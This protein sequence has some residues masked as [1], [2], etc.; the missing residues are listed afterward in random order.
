MRPEVPPLQQI[1]EN[2]AKS[3]SGN[4]CGGVPDFWPGDSPRRYPPSRI[5]Q[6]SYRKFR[7]SVRK[8]RSYVRK[9]PAIRSP[10]GQ[11][12]RRGINTPSPTSGQPAFGTLSP[13]LQ[14][15]A[16][17]D[18]ISQSLHSN[19]L[20]LGELKEKAMIYKLTKGFSISPSFT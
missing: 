18:E 8:F 5:F 7:A 1:L 2:M 13:P 17:I 14:A 20:K 16:Q 11:I 10:N 4:L 19:L 3:F 6:P 9:Y 12:S 15:K